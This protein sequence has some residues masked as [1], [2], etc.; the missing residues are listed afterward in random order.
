MSLGYVCDCVLHV[1]DNVG[2]PCNNLP[3]PGGTH[4]HRMSE[5]LCAKFVVLFRQ[6]SS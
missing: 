1:W 5:L 4:E 3:N 6:F 2:A